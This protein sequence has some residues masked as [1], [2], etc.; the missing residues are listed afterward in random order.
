[1]TSGL[2]QGGIK[3]LAVASTCPTSLTEPD[4]RVSLDNPF[5][6]DRVDLEIRLDGGRVDDL[7]S[8][9]RG[10]MLCQASANALAASARG[11]SAGDV[12]ALLEMLQAMLKGEQADDWP[13]SG[14]EVLALFE[15][16]QRHKHRHGCVTLPF[17][18][19][20]QA[21]SDLQGA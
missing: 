8:E 20:K 16:V 5:C 17:T 2:Y 13:P 6:G 11:M 19:L 18:A 7:A 12:A 4:R 9:V 3:A 10:C 21:L 15:P 14:W 1:M